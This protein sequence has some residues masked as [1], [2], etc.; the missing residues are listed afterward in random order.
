MERKAGRKVQ[1]LPRPSPKNQATKNALPHVKLTKRQKKQQKLLRKEF[2]ERRRGQYAAQKLRNRKRDAMA[3]EKIRKEMAQSFA[4][5][6]KEEIKLRKRLLLEK[7][8]RNANEVTLQQTVK[9]NNSIAVQV[10]EAELLRR[11]NLLTQAQKDEKRKENQRQQQLAREALAMQD[12]FGNSV[13]DEDFDP[14]SSYFD[15]EEEDRLGYIRIQMKNIQD[16]KLSEEEYG[17]RAEEIRLQLIH[18][19]QTSPRLKQGIAEQTIIL[20]NQFVRR[21]WLVDRLDLEESFEAMRIAMGFAKKD[22]GVLP[23]ELPEELQNI[24]LRF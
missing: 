18:L 13:P 17:A 5:R 20:Y 22:I 21:N 2:E 6:R 7:V 23:E 8:A 9:N 12:P 10:A 24:T 3:D 19:A 15:D 11:W 16:G 4:L 14:Y 1:M